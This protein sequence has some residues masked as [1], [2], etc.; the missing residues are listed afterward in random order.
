MKNKWKHLQLAKSDFGQSL[1]SFGIIYRCKFII[2]VPAIIE[3][4]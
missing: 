3:N 1:Y 2:Y 4:Q